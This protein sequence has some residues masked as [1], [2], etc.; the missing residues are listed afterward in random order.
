MSIEPQ[1]GANLNAYGC[2]MNSTAVDDAATIEQQWR[3]LTDQDILTF[4]DFS[5]VTQDRVVLGWLAQRTTARAKKLKE[6]FSAAPKSGYESLGWLLKRSP[7][8]VVQLVA[9]VAFPGMPGAQ[10]QFIEELRANPAEALQPANL[11][12]V[13]ADVTWDHE[14]DGKF[15]NSYPAIPFDLALPLAQC[16]SG[17]CELRRAGDDWE[18]LMRGSFVGKM[19]QNAVY[20]PPRDP[21]HRAGEDAPGARPKEFKAI[22][23]TAMH[24][25][26]RELVTLAWESFAS[27]STLAAQ[28]HIKGGWR[29]LA[30]SLGVTS[31]TGRDSIA[32]A[33]RLLSLLDVRTENGLPR[34]ILEILERPDGVEVQ[35]VNEL[36]PG[37]VR[38]KSARTNNR[39]LV[40]LPPH[41]P[42]A[43]GHKLAGR[44]Y[45]YQLLLLREMRRL[46]DTAK[47]EYVR[48]PASERQKLADALKLD[49]TNRE[50]L[51]KLWAAEN[52][53]CGLSFLIIQGDDVGV[54]Y[55]FSAS[56]SFLMEGGART[57]KARR[58]REKRRNRK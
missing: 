20:A 14:L 11:C 4:A 54:G 27:N 56:W 7:D 46:A 12:R 22:G 40:P 52:D 18:L 32:Q 57:L 13:V 26:L 41:L 47:G 28:I 30:A 16:L 9:S 15:A 35:L 51:E 48:I 42:L 6:H 25:V 31:G 53:G 17:E 3:D 23:S 36:W 34:S 50:S 5:S 49:R 58:N 43:P 39:R 29:G 37:A 24:R 33:G 38:R 1:P 19:R 45:S 44:A 10:A 21:H 8:R 2:P 55:N